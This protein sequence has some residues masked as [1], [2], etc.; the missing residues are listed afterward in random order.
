M[1][2]IFVRT[3]PSTAEIRKLFLLAAAR[4]DSP[5]HFIEHLDE[6]KHYLQFNCP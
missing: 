3:T 6:A 4:G 5:A 2:C 1:P